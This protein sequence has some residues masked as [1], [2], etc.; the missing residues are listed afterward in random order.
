M[1][2]SPSPLPSDLG[3]HFSTSEAVRRGV[4]RNRLRTK[5]LT[6]PFHGVRRTR[7]DI[8]REMADAAADT[9][10]G[11]I[12]RIRARDISA[13]ALAYFDASPAGRFLCG[14][15]AAAVRGY[16]VR[17]S[18]D[19]DIGVVAP[20]RA[21]RG[22][23]VKG[24]K[25]A[26]HLVEIE[27]L[28][29]VPVMTPASIWATLGRDLS[30]RELTIL[31]DA[32]LRVPRDQFGDLHPE[33]QGATIEQLQLAIV[34]GRRPGTARLH[35]AL[36]RARVGSASPLETD[37]RLDAEDAGLPEP[38]LDVEIFDEAG[39]R[40]GI[41]EIVYREQRV[42][43]EIEGDQHRTSRKQWVRDIAK[44]RAYADAGWEVVRVTSTDIRVHRTASATVRA[45]LLRRGWRP[46][47]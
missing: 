38:E 29:G 39:H 30:E 31:A 33:L 3:P 36:L 40:L 46:R 11:A 13:R 47:R 18:D 10:P 25:V 12:D 21:P 2:P 9:E 26:E 17:R 45:A 27:I 28:D 43:V 22:K 15:S 16:P 23:G 4:N 42:V 7:A 32:I 5:D 20:A 24:R 6:A 44:Y 8:A 35:A 1:P 19:L 37:Y 41:S 34:A 14:I